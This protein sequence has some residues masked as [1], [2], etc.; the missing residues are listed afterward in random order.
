[1]ISIV[2]PAYN[3]AGFIGDSLAQLLRS[4]E[5]AGTDADHPVEV[6]VVAN[7][8]SD[9]TAGQARAMAPGFAARGWRF[10]VI[11]QDEG[12]KTKALNAGIAAACNPRLV[13]MDA[14]IEVSPGLI[15]ALA[16]AVDRAE[17]VYASGTFHVRRTGNLISA[18]YARFWKRL[19]FMAEG[20]PGCG[21]SAVN[22]AGRARWEQIPEIIS[23]DMFIRSHFTAA[24][25][26]AVPEG[27]CWPIAEGF[28]ALVRVRRR[29]NRGMAELEEKYPDLLRNAGQTAPGTGEKI[30]LMLRDPP[31]FAVYAA[32]A[33]AVKTPL[34]GARGR[35]DRDRGA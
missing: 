7:G 2:I 33:L 31:G 32:V 29:Q 27:F 18:C 8:C 21:I 13:F 3:E 35:W 4:E 23:D 28:A 30:R 17:P 5:P 10:Q 6:I 9:D 34:F 26:I 25:R 15:A 16:R 11:E 20:V 19:P 24:E 14:D 22:A 12:S 1:M